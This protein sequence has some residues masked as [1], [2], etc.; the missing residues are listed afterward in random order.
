[1]NPAGLYLA[2]LILALSAALSSR[3]VAPGQPLWWA[4]TAIVA[5]AFVVERFM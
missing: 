2:I 5:A 3:R 1:M 4:C